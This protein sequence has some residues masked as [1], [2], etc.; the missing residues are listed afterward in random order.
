MGVLD[1]S[2]A[3]PLLL[4][5]TRRMLRII[6]GRC[7]K[8]IECR[9]VESSLRLT[10]TGTR[11]SSSRPA[12]HPASLCYPV[13]DSRPFRPFDLPLPRLEEVTEYTGEEEGVSH[14]SLGKVVTTRYAD[15]AENVHTSYGCHVSEW[16]CT[17]KSEKEDQGR[18]DK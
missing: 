5:A 16:N 7:A 8:D 14:F 4:P 3:T 13:Y 18:A 15:E 6:K 2:S 17:G 12:R 1:R 11:T 9:I 10:T